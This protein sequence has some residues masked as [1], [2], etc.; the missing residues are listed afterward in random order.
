MS[1]LSITN[2]ATFQKE[3]TRSRAPDKVNMF[4]FLYC[5]IAIDLGT[6][7]ILIYSKRNGIVVNEPS[8]VAFNS[9]GQPVAI[10]NEAL[11]I[12][13]RT[14]GGIR[15]VRPLRHG[16]IADF[17]TAEHMMVGMIKHVKKNWYCRTRKMVVCV[18]SGITDV[19]RRAVRDSA[20][21]AGAREVYLVDEP[22]AAAIGIGFDIH[23]HEGNMVVDIGGGTTEIAVIALSGV[24]HAQSVRLAGDVINESI[25]DYIRGHHNM[26]IGQRTAERIKFQI[27]SA[28]PLDQE[29]QMTIKG[30]DLVRGIPVARDI[31]SVEIRKA[32]S[33][34]VNT[35]VD[36]IIKSLDQTPPEFS[37]DLLDRGIY[38]AGGGA[39]LKNLDQLITDRTGLAV[40]IAEDPLTAVVR[41]T[42]IVLD[43]LD[44][45]RGVLS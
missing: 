29:L 37:A 4:E 32:I 41:G 11:S 2:T 45:Y 35:I 28:A 24:I 26:L 21:H 10:G 44:F 12:H 5:D 27:G 34:P 31:N 19:E 7:N 22:M 17:E 43:N 6:A 42:G 25:A 33:D 9:Q 39:L 8:I 16:V 30:R 13:E 1:T 18:P 36:S 3:I 38:L 15:T 14:H 20:H 40:H 23:D